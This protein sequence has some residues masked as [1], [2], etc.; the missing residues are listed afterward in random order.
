MDF[1]SNFSNTVFFF[2]DSNASKSRVPRCICS[3]TAAST[4][5]P[6]R[7]RGRK[8]TGFRVPAVPRSTTTTSWTG[9]STANG[10][11]WSL[12]WVER[13]I[14]HNLRERHS[15]IF[16]CRTSPRSSACSSRWVTAPRTGSCCRPPS[17]SA[18]S[19]ASIWST[20]SLNQ[21]SASTR[22]F[23]NLFWS[24]QIKHN[25]CELTFVTKRGLA[26]KIYIFY[27]SHSWITIT[28]ICSYSLLCL[29]RWNVERD[30]RYL[31]A[32]S[33]IPLNSFS[34]LFCTLFNITTNSH[35]C[36]LASAL[37]GKLLNFLHFSSCFFMLR[38]LDFTTIWRSGSPGS[39]HSVLLVCDS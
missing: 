20:L 18:G 26:L 36:Q 5:R 30:S 7:W 8:R 17:W 1:Q 32:G 25:E 4:G 27:I 34:L 15:R 14:L 13:E 31:L 37:R 16:F 29:A 10:R 21:V 33:E 23:C 24:Q 39:V 2:L 28:K 22:N 11:R 6:N 35:I 38:A 12:A 3:A 19:A 9:P